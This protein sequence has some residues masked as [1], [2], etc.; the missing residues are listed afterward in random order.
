MFQSTKVVDEYHVPVL[1]DPNLRSSLAE[2]VDKSM[3]EVSVRES[4]W[5]LSLIESLSPSK[6]VAPTRN[7]S[8]TYELN[9][10]SPKVTFKLKNLLL[11]KVSDVM[12][13]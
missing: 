12:Q 9:S 1:T 4:D 5:N 2:Y 8:V 3:I 6:N 11:S 10:S 13:Q 7:Q